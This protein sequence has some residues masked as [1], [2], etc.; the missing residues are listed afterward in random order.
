MISVYGAEGITRRGQAYDL[1]GLAAKER[2]ALSPQPPIL[3]DEGGKPRYEGAPERHFNLSHS[4]SLAL[5]A[6][7]DAPVGADIQIV[8][9]HRPG[10]PGRV[11]S[12]TELEW[13]ERGDTWERFT[14]LWVFKEALGKF[15][16]TGL[17]HPIRDMEVPVPKDGPGLYSAHGLWFRL[18]RGDGW[19]AAVC[20]QTPPPAEIRWL[21][22]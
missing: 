19:Y 10:L 15:R 21:T 3:R 4:G 16:G 7:G 5:Y 6:L 8:A 2:W 22:L 1:L 13:L 9:P 18:Y 11:C 17:T 12:P 14:Q 20:G